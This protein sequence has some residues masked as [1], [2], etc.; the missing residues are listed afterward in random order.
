MYCPSGSFTSLCVPLLFPFLPPS[1]QLICHYPS[2]S[3]ACSILFLFSF[4]FS[5]PLSLTHSVCLSYDCSSHQL[6]LFIFYSGFCHPLT[7]SSSVFFLSLALY[8]VAGASSLVGSF[9]TK[10]TSSI[11]RSVSVCVCMCVSLSLFL[12]LC[13]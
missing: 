4:T 1:S 11:P 12:F 7:T 3:F 13:L 10:F 6:E 5:L 2:K 9:N 8:S